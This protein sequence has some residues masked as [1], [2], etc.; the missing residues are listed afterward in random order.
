MSLSGNT[1]NVDDAFLVNDGNDTTTGTITAAGFTTAGSI[2]LGGHAVDD[3]DITSEASDAD[4]HLMTA[5][6]IKNRIEDYSYTTNTGTVTSVGTNT[7][8]SG[9]VTGSGNLS[10]ALNA[11]ADMGDAWD[12]STDE[13]IVLDDGVQKKKLSSEIFGSNAFNSTTI[14]TNNNQLTNGANYITSFTDTVDMGDGFTVTATSPGTNSTITEG[15]T[16]TI[17]AGTGISTTATSDGTIT[18]AN[19]LTSNATH[20]GDV[21][22]ATS[23]TIA[24]D[25]VTYAKMQNVATAN[26]VLG[27]SSADGAVSEVQVATAMI[28]DDAVTYAKLQHTATN[29]RVL[30]ATSAGVISEVQVSNAMLSGS[31]ADSKLSTISTANKVALT[32]LNING[33]SDIGANLVDGDF[34]SVYDVSATANKKATMSRLATYMQSSLSFTSNSDVDVNVANLIDRLEDID[35]NVT[36]GSANTVDTTISGDLTVTGDLLV[37]GTATTLDVATLEVTDLNITVAKDADS[38]AATNG[39]GLTFG[40]GWSTGTIPTLTYNHANTRLAVNVPLQAT[41]FVGNASTASLAA[42]AS[43]VAIGEHTNENTN[44]R[45]PFVPAG[46]GPDDNVLK[47]DSGFHYNPSTG[48]FTATSF[49][50]SVVGD[51][52]GQADTA[53][54]LHASVNINGV[55]FDGSTGIT[56]TADA[57]TL[58]GTS[59]KATVVG[60]SLTSVGTIATGVWNGTAIA[61]AFIADDAINNDKIAANAVRT[62]QIANDQITTDTIADDAITTATIADN[63]ITNATVADNAI[64]SDQINANAVVEAKIADDA[65]TGAK[66]SGFAIANVQVG[67]GTLADIGDGVGLTNSATALTFNTQAE[68]DS[69]PTS[70]VIDIGSEKIK[71][72]GK[73]SLSLT[74]L[75]RGHRGTSAAT[76]NANEG[77]KTEPAKQITLG[78]SRT[79]EIKQFEGADASN[80]TDTTGGLVPFAGTGDTAKFLRGDG[81]WST[82][83]GGVSVGTHAGNN[84]LAFFSSA[85]VISNS[86]NASFTS[87]TGAVDFFGSVEAGNVKIGTNTN[88]NTVE[89]SSAQDL[90]LRTN[91]GSNSGTVT[92]T[93]GTNGNITLTPNG[94]GDLV[95]DGLKWPQADG[96]A[97]YVLK[98]DGSAQLSWTEMSSGGD[99]NA[100]GANG[101]ASAPTFSFTSDTNTGMYRDS[102]DRLAFTTGGTKRFQTDSNGISVGSGSALAKINSLGNQN[103]ELST[104]QGITTGKIT[105]GHGNGGNISI[106][107]LGGNTAITNLT[108]TDATLTTPALGTPSA[109][110]LTN[111]T[112]LVATTGLTATGTASSSTYLRGDNTWATVSSASGDVSKVGTPVNNQIG[113]WTGDGTIEGDAKL[114]WDGDASVPQLQMTSTNDN[115]GWGPEL[116][117]YRNSAS[118]LANDG[119]GVMR[120]YGED[121]AG[122][123]DEYA[124]IRARISD[125]NSGTE[126]AWLKFGTVNA[127]TLDEDMLVLHAGKVGMGTAS[128]SYSLHVVDD[129]ALII[130]EDGS[131]GIQT[132]LKSGDAAGNVGTFTDST[133]NILT[134]D[135]ARIGIANSGAITFN[136][137][138]TFPTSD[139]SNGQVLQTNGSGTLSF[140]SAGGTDTYVIFAEEGDLYSGT[141]STGNAN[142]YQFS[143]GNGAQNSSKSSSGTDFGINVGVACKLVRLDITYGNSGNVSSGTTTFVVVKNGSNQSGNL[144]TSHTS[145]VHDTHHTS[146]DYDFAAG[147][148]FNLRTTTSSR[149]VG[150]FRMTATFQVA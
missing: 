50:G 103:L 40:S 92:L 15:D 88:K 68:V 20:T 11:L 85:G 91:G 13:F 82:P 59:L 141:G 63:Q 8:L 32:A 10:L 140:A 147:D 120:F 145:G 54:K 78:G 71:Y 16:L 17:A 48:R 58:T 42:V 133:F 131:S 21:T 57:T 138:Y 3:I 52:T 6:A 89:T 109:L 62:A 72:T 44:N 150:P 118:P 81:A 55:A 24:N 83:S 51:L 69:F 114:T 115:S 38:S 25:A 30:G 128:P 100:G 144:S 77:V 132:G 94:T 112:G 53:T 76:H 90:I 9:T 116:S 34:I 56:V 74:G 7:G 84:N 60:S 39:A 27:S 148:R 26:R 64:Q 18:V 102:S 35:S 97:N 14:P 129:S 67:A 1:L 123:K 37:S 45:I 104:N 137:E 126:D 134:N 86:N 108:A 107:P 33:A 70:G 46:A 149:Q 119:L 41:S 19:T 136:S 124:R 117:F 49:G 87:A 130:A 75:V 29:N 98:T 125:A 61:T 146:L 111:A 105:I 43:A 66:V 80:N 127:G 28:A 73:T 143:Y 2:T 31:I 22:G 79:L 96:T 142:G 135:T 95:L 110:V 47:T 106:V 12:D 99:T 23:L 4:D 36:I 122:N 5:L 121:T 93:N 113:V 65:V 101:S 139:G